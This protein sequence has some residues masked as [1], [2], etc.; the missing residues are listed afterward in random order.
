[1]HEIFYSAS[2]VLIAAILLLSMTGALEAGYRIGIRSAAGTSDDFKSHIQAIQGS[3]LGVLALLLGFTFSLA[4]QRYDTRSEAVATESNAIGTAFLRTDFLPES[5]R[6][7]VKLKMQQYT[8][9]RVE[10]GN[11]ELHRAAELEKFRA[12]VG[13]VQ[14]EIWRLT[15]QAAAELKPQPPAFALFVNSLNET[16]DASDHRDAELQRH[17]PEFILLVLY[18]TFVISSGVMGYAA[19]RA[20]HRPAMISYVLI[21]MIVLVAFIVID[22]DR[23]RRGL[24]RT[25]PTPMTQLKSRIDAELATGRSR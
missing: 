7:T 16:F 12:R 24:I 10:S 25:D 13:E 19:G 17:V 9:L 14:S 3:L 1:M 2:S 8:D 4:L 11:V 6:A 5:V 23:P 20:G 21:A 15:T 18:V 22:L